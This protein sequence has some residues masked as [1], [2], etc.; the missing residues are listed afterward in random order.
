MG[1]LVISD[2]YL[3]AYFILALLTSLL[4]LERVK[5]ISTQVICILCSLYLECYPSESPWLLSSLHST[6]LEMLFLS[7][8]SLGTLAPHPSLPIPCVMDMG[9]CSPDPLLWWGACCPAAGR[10]VSGQP[11]AVSPF[12]DCLSHR[13]TCLRSW[14]SLCSPHP[15]TDRGPNRKE[16]TKKDHFSSG[17][18][19]G[20]D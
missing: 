14:P 17:V 3:L 6:S 11:S 20:V 16:A 2:C 15:R 1:P 12:Q 4:F 5:N 8:L 13:W 10:A 19:H 7:T 18:P 9:L